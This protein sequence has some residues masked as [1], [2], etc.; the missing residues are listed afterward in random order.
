MERER[1]RGGKEKHIQTTEI[2]DIVLGTLVFS[3]RLLSLVTLLL[4]TRGKLRSSLYSDISEVSS[5]V[6][7]TVS[8][9]TI[10]SKV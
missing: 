10:T 6:I 9:V 1:R 5:L 7:M 3:F 8:S 4:W 2:N